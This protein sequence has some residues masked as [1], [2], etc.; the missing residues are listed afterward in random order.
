MRSGFNSRQESMFRKPLNYRSLRS[1][2]FGKSIITHEITSVYFLVYFTAL[3]FGSLSDY[4][5]IIQSSILTVIYIQMDEF[6]SLSV[7]SRTEVS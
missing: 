1:W 6:T 2:V 3:Y 7:S 5:N 4:C